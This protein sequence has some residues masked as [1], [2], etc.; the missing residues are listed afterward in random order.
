MRLALVIL[1]ITQK[2]STY[3]KTVNTWCKH[4]GLLLGRGNGIQPQ[5]HDQAL[6]ALR[7]KS[8]PMECSM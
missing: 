5:H 8:H 7:E 2:L 3:Q 6:R 4:S 1:L